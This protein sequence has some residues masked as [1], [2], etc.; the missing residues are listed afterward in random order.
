MERVLKGF[1]TIKIYIY[2]INPCMNNIS[3]LLLVLH[4]MK[5]AHTDLKPENMLFV[6]SGYDIYWNEN[7]VSI[8]LFLLYIFLYIN[9]NRKRLNLQLGSTLMGSI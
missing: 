3:F 9:L 4:S 1:K 8:V 5:L 7:L 2:K 6:D